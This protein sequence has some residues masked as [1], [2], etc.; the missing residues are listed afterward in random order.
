MVLLYL[1]VGLLVL[2][3]WLFVCFEL[4][5]CADVLGFGFDGCLSVI[6]DVTCVVCGVWSALF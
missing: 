1:C 6:V 5:W 4:L 3:W 2:S